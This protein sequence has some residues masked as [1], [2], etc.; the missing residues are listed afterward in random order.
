M[1]EP[2]VVG[3]DGSEESDRAVAWAA[4]DAAL[5]GRPLRIVHAVPS[6]PARPPVRAASQR[7]ERLAR[8]GEAIV[9][10]ARDRV[11]EWFPDV[12]TTVAVVAGDTP[13]VLRREAAEAFELVLAGRG[14]GGFARLLL[15]STSLRMA[16]RSTV[17]VV[18]VRGDAPDDGEI[19]AGI[20]LRPGTDAV[21]A[22]AFD[23]AALTGARLRVLHAW[24]MPTTLIDAGYTVE[25]ED[26]RPE[27]R[28]RVAEACEPLRDKYAQ[29]DAVGEVVLEHAVKALTNRSRAARLLVVGAP[30]RRW[31]APA[32][33]ITGHGVIH[34]A[35]C[36]VALVPARG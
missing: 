29:V 32:L 26:A 30:E 6:R 25:D 3:T 11:A 2:I 18:I 15:G 1:P 34:H 22:Y 20:D 4:A 9:H 16:A 24:Q 23:A 5:R 8:A 28:V 33:G 31:N 35:H 10:G 27:L 7:A 21:L 36:P 19:V 12:E 13:D 17:P 14:R